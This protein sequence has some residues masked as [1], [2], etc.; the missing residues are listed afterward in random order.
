ME[1]LTLKYFS[2][3]QGL[4]GS[5]EKTRI[6]EGKMVNPAIIIIMIIF[7]HKAVESV[8]PQRS[9]SKAS[10]NKTCVCVGHCLT[11]VFTC[12]GSHMSAQVAGLTETLPALM[13]EILSLPHERPQHA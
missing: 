4:I 12:M 9:V 10:F 1:G 7:S 11:A 2:T 13:T 5:E 8:G 6:C 3:N